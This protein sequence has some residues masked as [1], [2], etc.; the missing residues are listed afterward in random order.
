MSFITTNKIITKSLC[1]S[2]LVAQLFFVTGL[3]GT[4]AHELI[5]AEY[6]TSPP[7]I[8]VNYDMTGSTVSDHFIEHNH[9]MVYLQGNLV[10]IGLLII[11]LFCLFMVMG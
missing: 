10:F 11:D 6:A 8:S 7:A 5:H 1:A 4:L 2:L 3:M 9:N